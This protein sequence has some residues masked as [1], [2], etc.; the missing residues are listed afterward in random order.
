MEPSQSARKPRGDWVHLLALA[1]RS[2]Q[3][4][5]HV[6][7][8]VDDT[9]ATTPE[10]TDCSR[11]CWTRPEAHVSSGALCHVCPVKRWSQIHQRPIAPPVWH[12]PLTSSPPPPPPPPP[13]IAACKQ[14]SWEARF[15]GD[16]SLRHKPSPRP[17]PSQLPR[18]SAIVAE[19]LAIC[20]SRLCP[21]EGI[22]RQISPEL[23]IYR[24]TTLI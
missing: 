6:S 20:V 21:N 10:R 23:N 1:A 22:R 5:L 13:N 18:F 14:P 2:S 17:S 15:S 4:G 24:Q 3:R 7:S 19:I 12:R 11:I 16:D 9:A 8:A